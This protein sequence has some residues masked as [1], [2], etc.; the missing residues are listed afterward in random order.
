MLYIKERMMPGSEQALTEYQSTAFALPYT[1][2]NALKFNYLF[3][4]SLINRFHHVAQA[5]P[6]DL[7]PCFNL[8]YTGITV[9][10]LNQHAQL[11]FNTSMNHYV[12]L[13]LDFVCL[14]FKGKKI[15]Q[16]MPVLCYVVSAGM[17][18]IPSSANQICT[19]SIRKRSALC[20]IGG[21]LE[22]GL[23]YQ[24]TVLGTRVPSLNSVL[25][26]SPFHISHVR[27]LQL[28]TLTRISHVCGKGHCPEIISHTSI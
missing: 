12:V 17:W 23:P 3:M 25:S 15:S 28:T 1:H 13:Q 4:C 27:W 8:P 22:G 18:W 14:F 10:R 26:H 20:S 6:P 24:R 16:L 7:V 2:W 11:I 5:D 19:T 9:L 21:W